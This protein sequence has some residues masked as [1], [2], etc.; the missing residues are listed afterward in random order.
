MIYV[1]RS[2]LFQEICL[3]KKQDKLTKEALNL[4][5]KIVDEFS[6]KFYYYDEEDRKDCKAQAAMDCFMYWRG[7]DPSSGKDPFSYYTQLIKN[8]YC[9]GW[10]RLHKQMPLH[11]RVSIDNLHSL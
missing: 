1:Q 9:K 7:Y 3:S 2:V 5:L 10:N 8:G 6:H 4:L 11:L